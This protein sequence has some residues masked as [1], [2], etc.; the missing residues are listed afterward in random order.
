MKRWFFP[1]VLVSV[2]ISVAA[3]PQPSLNAYFQST[4]K[5]TAYQKKVFDRVAAAWKMPP[6]RPKVGKKSVVQSVIAKDGK[7]VSAVVSMES[8][9]KAWDDAALAAVK[10]AA[11]FDPLPAGYGY[12]TLQVHFHIAWVNPD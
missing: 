7:L 5:D 9:S 12:S 11:P 6:S 2:A 10:A 8:G 1:A 4:L 3:A